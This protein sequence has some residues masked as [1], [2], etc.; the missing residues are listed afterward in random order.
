MF[1]VIRGAGD[2]ATGIATRL[3]R[4]GID[5]AMLDVA[6]PTAVRRSVAFS[7]AVRLGTS[8]VEGICAELATDVATAKAIIAKGN[9]AV[10]VDPMGQ[11]IAD[12]KP[13]CVVDA[14][15]AKQNLGTT[16]DMAPLVIGVGP[17]F[18]AGPEVSAD[19][20]ACIETK[21]GHYLGRVIW[22]GS[23]IPNTGVPGNIGGYSKERVLRA[24]ATGA[25]KPVAHIGDMV[26]KGDV[27]AYVDGKPMVATLTG[28]LR[29]LL[30][31]D[32]PVE[33]GMKSG[34]ID[35]RCK[36]SH[37]FSCSDKTRA[38]AGGVLEAILTHTGALKNKAL[39]KL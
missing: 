36:K 14:I 6:V 15:L 2:I 9:I 10:L 26:K 11:T 37:C 22:D 38:I 16:K 8:Q 31:E 23:P 30:Q 21:R 25:F 3:H 19:C 1:V 5:I 33:E 13:D 4:C 32:C 7:E 17:G 28:I 27:L 34:D 35:P 20:H 12:F 39:H 24:P 18:H 29:G